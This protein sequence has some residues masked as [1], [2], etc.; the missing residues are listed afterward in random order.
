MA[1]ADN[2][3]CVCGTARNRRTHVSIEL[4][5]GKQNYRNSDE[6][7]W[8][9]CAKQRD[10]AENR[11]RLGLRV[12]SKNHGRT[13][14]N[15]WFQMWA[16][17]KPQKQDI[18]WVS[19]WTAQSMEVN[20]AIK[21]FGCGT[22]WNRSK[23]TQMDLSMESEKYGNG[24]GINDFGCRKSRIVSKRIFNRARA[25]KATNHGCLN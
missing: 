21:D 9:S 5:S 6:K 10:I 8:F 7:S 3:P 16:G 4:Q 1:F 20:M 23:R 22:T 19:V 12:E 15:R 25:W 11:L 2:H 24:W 14:E 17:V 18:D 13:F